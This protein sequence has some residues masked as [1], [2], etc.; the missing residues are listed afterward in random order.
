MEG[1]GIERG[2]SKEEGWVRKRGRSERR[3]GWR[4]GD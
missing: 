2:G 4:E 1:R 3:D